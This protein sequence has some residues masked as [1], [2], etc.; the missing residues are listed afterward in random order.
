MAC[1]LTHT[2]TRTLKRDALSLSLRLVAYGRRVIECRFDAKLFSDNAPRYG[3]A[4]RRIKINFS[5]Y[6]KNE[7][8]IDAR[9]ARKR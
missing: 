4:Q 9:A 7:I 8:E 5:K 3:R 6:F 2:H 1:A